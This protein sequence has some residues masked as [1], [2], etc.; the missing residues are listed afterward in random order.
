MLSKGLPWL[1]IMGLENIGVGA[2]DFTRFKCSFW[3]SNYSCVKK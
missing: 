1:E 2:V 3:Q